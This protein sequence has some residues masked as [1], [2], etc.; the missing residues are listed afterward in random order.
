M[1][2]LKG[3]WTAFKGSALAVTAAKWAAVALAV[4]LVLF[5]VRQSGRSDARRE[6]AEEI[7][8]R[9]QVANEAR[10]EVRN[11]ADRGK[12]PPERVRKFYVD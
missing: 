11:A 8:K 5:K 12:P 6:M 4:L 1:L 9:G 3:L 7:V 10:S 2:W